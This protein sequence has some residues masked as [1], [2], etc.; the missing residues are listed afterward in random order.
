MTETAAKTIRQFA[1]IAP[2][3]PKFAESVL[4]LIDQQNEYVEGP[5][6][7][8]GMR[9][10]RAVNARVLAAARAAGAAIVHVAQLGSAGGMFD[11]TAHRG[12][13]ID[14]VQPIDGEPIV[15][16]R[17]A[18]SFAGTTLDDVLAGIGRKSL[19]ITGYMTHNCV[20]GTAFDAVTRGLAVTIIADATATRDLP[21]GQGGV[22]PAA[23][24]QQAQLTGLSDRQALILSSTELLSNQ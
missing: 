13:F 7:L 8:S 10:A 23:V 12:A 17:F 11:R 2:V 1:G 4:L 3:V 15:E 6:A 16:K 21:D 9:E 18:S 14:E 5:L 22:V 19:I 20:T 24:L